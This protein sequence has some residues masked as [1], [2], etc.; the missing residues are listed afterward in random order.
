[1]WNFSFFSFVCRY[2]LFYLDDDEQDPFEQLK[3][4]KPKSAATPVT[5]SAATT[6]KKAAPT[7]GQV[8]NTN[9]GKAN[10]VNNNNSKTAEKENK[11]SASNK[12]NQNNEKSGTGGG[13]GGNNAQRSKGIKETQNVKTLD[14]RGPRD[15]KSTNQNF[16]FSCFLVSFDPENPQKSYKFSK[17]WMHF[18][19]KFLKTACFWQ[20]NA[21]IA[22]RKKLT[23][24]NVYACVCARSTYI[25]I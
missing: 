8:I 3:Q 18:E 9:V 19:K 15:G 23:Q 21:H 12:S 13:K 11:I 24:E 6:G 5:G 14:N 10:N 1:M 20:T 4:K 2:D 22:A 17:T 16:I 7:A 25:H